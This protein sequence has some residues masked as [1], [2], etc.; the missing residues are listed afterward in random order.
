MNPWLR[1]GGWCNI[2]TSPSAARKGKGC[3]VYVLPLPATKWINYKTL[4][5]KIFP[6]QGMQWWQKTW[7]ITQ[8]NSPYSSYKSN[9]PLALAVNVKG[10]FRHV[11]TQTSG[12]YKRTS[13][14]VTTKYI[15]YAIYIKISKYQHT[16]EFW[17]TFILNIY[18]VLM[19]VHLVNKIMLRIIDYL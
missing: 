15:T 1:Y 5:C 14:A 11:R 9:F 8:Y 10:C 18:R 12:L 13:I 19:H 4:N 6:C 16:L 3:I 7:T 2:L 17:N